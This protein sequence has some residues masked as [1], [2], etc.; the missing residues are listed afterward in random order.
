MNNV[1]K[2]GSQGEEVKKL[3]GFL[4]TTGYNPG[5]IDGIFGSKTKAAVIRFQKDYGI[6]EDG[7]V[8]PVTRAKMAERASEGI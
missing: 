7:I 3:Q 8:G 5:A 4:T 1:L 2:E 6:T